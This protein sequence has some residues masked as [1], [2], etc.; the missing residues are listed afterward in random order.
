MN[1]H[2]MTSQSLGA[3]IRA[4]RKSRGLNLEGLAA[5][6]NR[7]VGWLSQV[8]RDLSTPNIDDLKQ[9]SELFDVPLSIFFGQAE[10]PAREC[11]YIVRR[12][13]RRAIGDED[14][15]VESLLSPDLT[16]S[17]EVLHCSFAPGASVKTHVTRETQEVG[18]LITGRLTIWINDVQFDL[19]TGDSF[20]VRGE[21]Y[22]WS[23]PHKQAAEVIWVI[24]PPVY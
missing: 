22:R 15:L 18:T 19:D 12:N 6:L 24:S 3:D 1:D 13:A 11:G 4:L 5:K 23:N 21:S 16:D 8:E 7:S 2:T 9:F 17:F 20:R 14:G 10:A